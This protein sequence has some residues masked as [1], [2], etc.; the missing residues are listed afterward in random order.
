M[1]AGHGKR[2]IIREKAGG[3]CECRC[4]ALPWTGLLGK[5]PGSGLLL[6]TLL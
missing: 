3:S 1:V 4:T 2:G 6:G 5:I